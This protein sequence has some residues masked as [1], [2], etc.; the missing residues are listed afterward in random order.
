M[1]RTECPACSSLNKVHKYTIDGYQINKCNDCLS[2]FVVNVPP[3]SEI[4]SQYKKNDYY[5]LPFDSEQRINTE[6]ARRAKI[7][8]KIVKGGKVLDIG[9]AKGSFLNIMK[10]YDYDTFGIEM[11]GANVEI[12]KD[13]GHKVFHGD[14]TSYYDSTLKQRFN[15]IACL[16][17]IEHIADPVDFLKKIKS[18]LEVNSILVL[19]T[20]NF[21]GFVSKLLGRR[22]PFII[23]P[24]HLNFFSKKGLNELV[25]VVGLRPIKLTTFGF[26]TEEGLN[27]TVTKYF[28]PI[29]N[30]L[31]FLLK[32]LINYTIKSLNLFKQGLELELYIKYE[33]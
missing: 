18:L 5:T 12:C 27:R 14:L 29:L 21:S 30:R 10:K 28:P 3:E 15:I 25:T 2:L 16:D 17:V 24:E 9:C 20:P 4:L 7:I 6:N 31:S 19:S 32:P 11:S 22:D 8:T 1:I 23:P 33:N 13:Q 26:I